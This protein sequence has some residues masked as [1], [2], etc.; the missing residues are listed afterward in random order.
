MINM[1]HPGDVLLEFNCRYDKY[2][3][4]QLEYTILILTQNT[5]SFNDRVKSHW[6][7]THKKTINWFSNIDVD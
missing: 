7:D 6:G 3:I 2:V 1:F 5:F 4:S